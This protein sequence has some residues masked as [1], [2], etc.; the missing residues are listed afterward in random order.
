MKAIAAIFKSLEDETRLRIIGLLL[1]VDDLCV[2]HIISVLQLPQSTVSRHLATLKNAGWLN[3]RREGLWIHYSLAK[4]LGPIH[5]VLM[6]A[7]RTIV[8]QNE[9]AGK[10]RKRLAKI[11]KENRC[12]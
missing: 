8:A 9:L 3:D 12:I 5:R 11:S 6:S 2:C 7:V 10:D 1:D 4:D